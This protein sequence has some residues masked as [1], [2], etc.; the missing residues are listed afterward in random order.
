MSPARTPEQI[1]ASLEDHRREL[2]SSIELLRDDVAELSDWRAQIRKHEKPAVIA[3]AVAGFV[4][5]GGIG[6]FTGLLRRG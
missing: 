3:A 1:R 5:A 2:T 4:L 6:G